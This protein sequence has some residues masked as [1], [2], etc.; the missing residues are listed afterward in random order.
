MQFIK[1]IAFLITF[2][3]FYSFN[4]DLV[5]EIDSFFCINLSNKIIRGISLS[6]TL[7]ES[8]LIMIVTEIVHT[9]FKNTN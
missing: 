9:P 7:V 2:G 5:T 3:L 6:L 4:T 8:S 1:V